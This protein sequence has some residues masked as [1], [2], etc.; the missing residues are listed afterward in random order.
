MKRINY[1]LLAIFILIPI[2]IG[3]IL[4]LLVV[5]GSNIDSILPSYIFPIVWTILYTLMGIS[6]YIVYNELGYIPRIYI[7]QLIVNYLWVIIFFT[8]RAF[9]LAFIWIILLMILV[10]I[11][12]DKFRMVS[13]T[14][15]NLQIPYLIWL[16]IA[17]ILNLMF[18]L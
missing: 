9:L 2:I 6:S 1:K 12:I 4:G 13:K 8:F 5:K 3:T 15:G 7:I 17:G 14:A 10:I 16:I 18:I 11:M